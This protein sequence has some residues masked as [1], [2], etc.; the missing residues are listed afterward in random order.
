V[1]S[2]VTSFSADPELVG[3]AVPQ[4]PAHVVRA[5]TVYN[6]PQHWTIAALLRASSRQF[7]DDLNQLPLDAYSV[8]GVSISR[9]TGMLTWFGSA[10]N[11]FDSRIQTTA[12]PVLNY[13]SPR[14]ISAGIKFSSP[15]R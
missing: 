8:A 11:V 6:A 14:I 1:H 3:K 13:A 5:S 15:T 9:Q 4:V 7:D 12:T 2:L 10:S